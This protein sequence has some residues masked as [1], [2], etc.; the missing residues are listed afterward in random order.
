MRN[1][2]AYVAL[3]P[4]H[5]ITLGGLTRC[6]GGGGQ[7]LHAHILMKQLQKLLGANP[8]CTLANEAAT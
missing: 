3:L 1:K 6:G 4:A 8:A 2:G 7:T 5:A